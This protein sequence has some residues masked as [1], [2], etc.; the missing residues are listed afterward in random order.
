M[1]IVLKNIYKGMK[2]S[3]LLLYVISN[4][5]LY[6]FLTDKFALIAGSYKWLHLEKGINRSIMFLIFS[7]GST[8]ILH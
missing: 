2:K 6:C 8:I 4:K 7:I 5:K 3:L 1:V